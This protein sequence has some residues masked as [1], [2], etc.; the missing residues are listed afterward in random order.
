M[1]RSRSSG[2]AL[3]VVLIFLMGMLVLVLAV[4]SRAQL[5]RQTSTASAASVLAEVLAESATEMI[6]GD[7]LHEIAA[8]SET[9]DL[10]TGISG[11]RK[12]FQPILV[13]TTQTLVGSNIA[14]SAAPS[15]L[16]QRVVED[17]GGAP[18]NLVKQSLQ[19]QPAFSITEGYRNYSLLGTI[20][21]RASSV[22]STI[23]PKIGSAVPLDRWNLPKL[24]RD[25]E[26]LSPPDW[27]YLNRKGENP[28]SFSQSMTAKSKSNSEFVLGRFAY[29]IYDTGGLI[30]INVAGN[31]LDAD[32]NVHRGRLHQVSLEN[33]P[34]P[35][36]H[37]DFSEFLAWRSAGED[38]DSDVNAKEGLFDA[39]RTFIK[40]KPG[41]QAF[42]TRQDLLRFVMQ[43]DGI[44][45][46]ALPFLT[47]FSRDVNAPSYTPE[48]N[49]PKLPANPPPDEMNPSFPSARF[50]AETL[51]T[52]GLDPDVTVPAGTPVM[53]RR[54]PLSKLSL[55][56]E[57]N[58]D[59]ESLRYYFGLV[60]NPDGSFSYVDL[61]AG[62]IGRLPEVANLG[63]EPN[64]FEVL[65]AT[66]TTGSL[67]RH[68]ANSYTVDFPRDSQ[69]NLQIMQIGANIIDQWDADDLPTEL[70][71]PDASGGTISSY[72]VEN[73][74]YLNNFV[75]VPHRPEWDRGRFQVWGIFDVWNPHRN[76]STPPKEISGFRILALEGRGHVSL[77]Y[78]LGI[79]VNGASQNPY[80][81][82][83]TS[84]PV[85]SERQSILQL[86]PTGAMEFETTGDYSE[87]TIVGSGLAP[88]DPSD[89]P[90]FLFWEAEYVP[91][92]IPSKTDRSAD[93]QTKLNTLMDNEFPY[94][95]SESF[96]TDASTGDRI[97]PDGTNITGL[98]PT[99]WTQ[100]INSTGAS[101]EIRIYANFPVKAHNWFRYTPAAH[102]NKTT[103][104]LQ[105]R[106]ADGQWRTYQVMNQFMP[107]KAGGEQGTPL[108]GHT[109]GTRTLPIAEFSESWKSNPP[110]WWKDTHHSVP[111][112]DESDCFY[113]WREPTKLISFFKMDPRTIR[114]G[115]YPNTYADVL[116][117]TIRTSPTQ[118]AGTIGSEATPVGDSR[119]RIFTD[120]DRT[121]GNYDSTDPDFSA[122]GPS[123]F[124]WH[125]I[126]QHPT[127]R[128][129]AMA[130]MIN[131][132]EGTLST[133]SQNLGRYADLDGVIR[134]ADGYLGAMPT[135]PGRMLERPTILNRPF[136]S[137]GE[138]GYVFRD[139]PWKTLDFFTPNSADLGLLDVFSIEE[140]E[141][142]TP[143][144]AGKVNLNSAPPE[145]LQTLLV[146]SGYHAD[147]PAET[148][149]A[150]EAATLSQSIRAAAT[151]VPFR[152]RGDLVTRAL[153]SSAM[154]LTG[155][156]TSPGGAGELSRTK[157]Q[158]E[159]AIRT[160][161]EIGSTRTWNLLVDLIVQ[162]GNFIP[163]SESMSDFVVRAERHFWI[164]LAIDRLTGEVVAKQTEEVR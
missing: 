33:A 152:D 158:R 126:G 9:D 131:A 164:H 44:R 106:D 139:L 118:V 21:N 143:V 71:Y 37:L 69:R 124:S 138:L 41:S 97:Y 63:R 59:P 81:P 92:A 148:M 98:N 99:Y 67:G 36:Q 24:A 141:D 109:S 70:R 58:P 80:S 61:I 135:V 64:F 113:G 74:P 11:F 53:V 132:P 115:H 105:Y 120:E 101:N 145:V 4:F 38:P 154:N 43:T 125:N 78:Q 159:A 153:G 157:I 144:V 22:N 149:N 88:T 65:Q 108:S 29:N 48:P 94:V 8:G 156:D 6:I 84:F 28:A 136:R 150:S 160:L 50:A 75:M 90:A 77:R 83:W 87:P 130:L 20:P 23:S 91:P 107:R 128:Y 40:V 112:F 51:L 116:G 47:T 102:P 45:E 15:M 66:I 142:S 27:I 3:V 111:G 1:K 155:I 162:T 117:T 119:W 103:F 13:N 121:P 127:R 100:S 26:N 123:N 140:P 163:S 86:N 17:E 46:D 14:I 55:L 151:T 72:G 82:L 122:F 16:I 85:A 42:V 133:A 39:T 25:D 7:L 10:A 95:A 57:E 49:R 146:G 161:S 52:R 134:A 110:T 54:F 60:K 104:H 12:V 2:V 62:R 18:I 68:A 79:R 30:D 73:L 114:F 93:L 56:S 76:A 34:D 89:R 31:T 19:N 32:Q 137:V 147:F 5:N 96:S 35:L 129:G